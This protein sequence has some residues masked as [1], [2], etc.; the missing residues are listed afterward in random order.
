MA[1]TYEPLDLTRHS[2]R[3]LKILPRTDDNVIS[4]SLQVVDLQDVKGGYDA[5]SYEWGQESNQQL[6]SVN[7][8]DLMIRQN[9]WRFLQHCRDTEFAQQHYEYLWI[10]AIC[11]A[12]QNVHERNH[13]VMQMSE[14]FRGARQVI[15]WL[16]TTS[17]KTNIP[18][19]AY[20]CI[21]D[22]HHGTKM[23]MSGLK[24]NHE[25]EAKWREK[26]R[27]STQRI[28][29]DVRLLFS[30]RY[31]RR[32][33]VVQEIRLARKAVAVTGTTCVNNDR[34]TSMHVGND[35]L[36]AVRF[37]CS[38][39]STGDRLDSLMTRCRNLECYE[40]LD[41]IYGLLGMV[42][43]GQSFVVDYASG[44]AE[45]LMRAVE[46]TRKQ[47]EYVFCWLEVFETFARHLG[48][49]QVL[50]AP[51]IS[52]SAENGVP[53]YHAALTKPE[54][55]FESSACFWTDVTSTKCATVGRE[56][57]D[58]PDEWMSFGLLIGRSRVGFYISRGGV[59][60]ETF[61][62]DPQSRFETTRLENF[63]QTV[64]FEQVRRQQTL[65][66]S[67]ERSTEH[68][69]STGGLEGPIDAEVKAMERDDWKASCSYSALVELHDYRIWLR[70]RR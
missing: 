54:T 2:I 50:L 19:N 15:A 23:S 43:G 61:Q 60:T 39:I 68:H 70:Q 5:V 64:T 51:L 67:H 48:L 18:P 56:W 14:I 37:V 45:V 24:P 69:E 28:M 1:Y 35:Q 42:K 3:L 58:S 8:K 10:D 27:Q 47:F 6:I 49:E 34:L 65:L 13:Q 40:P 25:A 63:S 7:G 59:W 20:E 44:A 57:P 62:G 9:I 41:R 30:N 12:Q 55:L 21:Y 26:S 22:F 38:P 32:L 53:K 33:W 66:S 17:I 4:L 16:G 52:R 11:I 36:E 29:N 46:F 31:W